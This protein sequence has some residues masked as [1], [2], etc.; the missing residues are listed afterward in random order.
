MSFHLPARLRPI[1]GV[2]L[3]AGILA[4][5]ESTTNRD[6]K[7]AEDRAAIQLSQAQR[8]REE[9][10]AQV[11]KLQS[12]LTE[13]RARNTLNQQQ[14]EALRSDLNRA[15]DAA[16]K[17]QADAQKAQAQAQKAAAQAE[18]AAADLKRKLD[19]SR[20]QTAVKAASPTT[21]PNKD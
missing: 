6:A 14:I 16:Q 20:V 4:G 15:L 21:A 12:D 10:K 7:R 3:V 17:A 13:A 1:L 19:E 11:D 5:C 18:T 2:L 9:Y 8:E